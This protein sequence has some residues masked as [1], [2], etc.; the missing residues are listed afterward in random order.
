MHIMTK[1]GLLPIDSSINKLTN[2]QNSNAK[3]FTG[4]HLLACF[5]VLS[6]VHEYSGVHWMP[7]VGSYLLEIIIWL[8]D[9]IGHGFSYILWHFKCNWVLV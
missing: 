3:K 5:W 9:D 7:L 2:Y 4:L 6:D 1:N 8:I